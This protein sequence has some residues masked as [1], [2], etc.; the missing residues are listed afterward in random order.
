[1]ARDQLRVAHPEREVFAG[2]VSPVHDG[3]AKRYLLPAGDRIVMSQGAVASSRWIVVDPWE[4]TQP[5]YSL[6]AP[7]LKHVE[8]EF[9]SVLSSTFH[10]IVSRW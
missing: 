3:Y 10:F 1:M 2:I 9:N 8:D 6:T 7:V 4:A 5:V